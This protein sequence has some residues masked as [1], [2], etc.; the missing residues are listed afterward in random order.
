MSNLSRIAIVAAGFIAASAATA[1]ADGCSETT[2]IVQLVPGASIASFNLEYGTTTLDAI[3]SRNIFLIELADGVEFD[4]L[5]DLVDSDPDVASLDED[6]DVTDASPEGGTRTIFFNSTSGAFT[7]QVALDLIRIDDAQQFALGAG[8][9]VAVIDTGVSAHPLVS[10]ALDPGYNFVSNN[11]NASDVG[12]GLDNDGD[13]L[14][15]EMVGHGTF[16]AG[17][18]L[19]VAPAARILPVRVMDDEGFATTFRLVAGIYYAVDQGAHVLNISMGSTEA[20]TVILDA[21][22]Y[23]EA[24]NRTVVASSGN[25]GTSSPRFL[26]GWSSEGVIAVTATTDADLRADFANFGPYVSISAPGVLLTSINTVNGYVAA[27]GTSF[28]APLTSGVIALMREANPGDTAAQ[29]RAMLMMAAV[30]IDALN[31]G[32]EGQLGAGRLDAAAAVGVSCPGDVDGDGNVDISDLAILLSHFGQTVGATFADGD[33]DGD[34][35]VDL[36][37]LAVLLAAFGRTCG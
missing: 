28:A 30:V 27:S 19:R 13:G 23:A 12:D 18:V 22:A 7:G 4:Q 37:D 9:V 34:G 16:V 24:Q 36:N 35:D 5:E 2:A 33:F 26:A 11:T 31:P 32:Y 1:R 8:V 10:S 21:I 3:A 14:I 20:S 6:C 25:E 29:L 17:L 15:D